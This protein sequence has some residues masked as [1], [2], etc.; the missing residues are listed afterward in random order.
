MSLA[1]GFLSLA[2]ACSLTKGGIKIVQCLTA[3]ILEAE[4]RFSLD[5][6]G[7]AETVMLKLAKLSL[8]L[9]CQQHS[10]SPV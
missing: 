9:W 7:V 2:P 3:F 8:K 5:V 4:V 6:R 10:Q 1:S